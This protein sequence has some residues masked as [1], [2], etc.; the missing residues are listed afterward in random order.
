VSGQFD[1][2]LVTLQQ[3]ANR[4]RS[5]AGDLD[6]AG[7]PPAPPDAGA[8]T[9]AV[10]A[11]LSFLTESAAGVAEGIGAAGDAVSRSHELYDQVDQNESRSLRS[12]PE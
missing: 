10:S 1:A 7:P 11:V 3:V 5:A 6:A 2:D 4:L 8:C 12:S 9:A